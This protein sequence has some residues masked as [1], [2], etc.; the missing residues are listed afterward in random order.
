MDFLKIRKFIQDI[1][2]G[3]YPSTYLNTDINITFSTV[4][5]KPRQNKDDPKPLKGVHIL[6]ISKRT[7]KCN[8]I[9]SR[10]NGECLVFS[11]SA[12]PDHTEF[13]LQHLRFGA[14]KRMIPHFHSSPTARTPERKALY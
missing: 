14:E 4:S 5:H 10:A 6:G 1:E 3:S 7:S 12:F 9:E 8:R 13:L 11:E 2:V